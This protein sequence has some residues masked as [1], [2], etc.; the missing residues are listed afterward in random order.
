MV[1]PGPRS[2]GPGAGPGGNDNFAPTLTPPDGPDPME[3]L[4]VDGKA[5]IE[6][7][8]Q[9]ERRS[10]PRERRAAPAPESS[11]LR[12][13]PSPIL[14]EIEGDVAEA[15]LGES[16]MSAARDGDPLAAPEEGRFEQGVLF[17]SRLLWPN[18]AQ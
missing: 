9:A 3:K 12:P 10:G 18:P 11:R 15:V 2:S 5:L 8:G 14:E 4:L 7:S 1:V 16:G 6:A 17:R 13:S